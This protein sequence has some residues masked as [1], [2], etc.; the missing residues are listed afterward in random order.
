MNLVGLR[1][2]L[3]LQIVLAEGCRLNGFPAHDGA[4]TS[5]ANFEY[6]AVIAVSERVLVFEGRSDN[7]DLCLLIIVCPRVAENRL[8]PCNFI[9]SVLTYLK[10]CVYVLAW[11]GD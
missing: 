3:L 2:L 6:Q 7:N 8:Q 1:L 11:S 5:G 4:E 10:V 9:T